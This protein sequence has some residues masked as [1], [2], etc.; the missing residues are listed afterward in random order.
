MTEDRVGAAGGGGRRGRKFE[1]RE[2]RSETWVVMKTV[3]TTTTVL[4]VGNEGGGRRG[5]KVDGGCRSE[6]AG[7]GGDIIDDG[8][9][10]GGRMMLD[11]RATGGCEI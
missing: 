2:V 1:G 10:C 6:V 3:S 7:N 9:D 11:L 5:S 8:V 4:M